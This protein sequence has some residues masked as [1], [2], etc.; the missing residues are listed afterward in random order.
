MYLDKSAFTRYR[1]E[2]SLFA[3]EDFHI[4]PIETSRK[5]YVRICCGGSTDARLKGFAEMFG[6]GV[7]TVGDGFAASASLIGYMQAQ[8]IILFFE[9]AEDYRKWVDDGV[10][11][12][13]LV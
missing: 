5:A 9:D 8:L 3:P 12:D 4:G 1:E 10:E 6:A 13:F 11:L 2:L 7:Y